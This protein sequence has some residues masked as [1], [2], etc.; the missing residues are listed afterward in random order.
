MTEVGNREPGMLL[1]LPQTQSY[2]SKCL[3]VISNHPIPTPNS[4]LHNS[5]NTQ[6]IPVLVHGLND[7]FFAHCPSHPNPLV[8][9]T[10]KYILQPTGLNYTKNININVLSIYC[11]NQL[12]GSRSG[13]SVHNFSLPLFAPIFIYILFS[14]T[15]TI[16]YI[17]CV[18]LA[19]KP[20]ISL[21]ILT[22]MKIFHEY[23][24]V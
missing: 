17:Q 6:P 15:C 2:P 18:P 16:V 8:Q 19:T 24:F 3:F 14:S 12:I 5:L 13:F 10:G 1:Q 9:Q 4:H 11:F 23:V 7:K 21:I 20:G 22:S